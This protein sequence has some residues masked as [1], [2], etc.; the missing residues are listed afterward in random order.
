LGGWARHPRPF[1]RC[2]AFVLALI[3]AVGS[4]SA[5][6]PRPAAAAETQPTPA[7]DALA[8]ESDPQPYAQP[9]N[10]SATALVMR[11]WSFQAGG[12]LGSIVDRVAGGGTVQRHTDF[13][14]DSLGRVTGE[15]VYLGGV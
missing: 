10:T 1:Q 4:M 15:V 2:V 3:L 12:R 5:A 11:E 14:H 6:P 13:G 9:A 7:S 8:V